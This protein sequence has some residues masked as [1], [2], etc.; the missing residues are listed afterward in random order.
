M[1][2]IIILTIL[3]TSF[4]FSGCQEAERRNEEDKLNLK[5]EKRIHN[6]KK[7]DYEVLLIDRCQYILYQES[8]GVNLAYGFMSHKGN[9]N[10]PIH[11]FQ[12]PDSILNSSKLIDTLNN[13]TVGVEKTKK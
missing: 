13:K 10:N 8:E 7:G 11:C 9:C 2:A 1:K 3:V 12:T 6:I 4:I 5:T